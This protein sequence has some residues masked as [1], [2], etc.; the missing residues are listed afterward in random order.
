MEDGE[1][2][3]RADFDAFLDDIETFLNITKI[4]DDNIQNSGITGSTKLLNQSVTAAKLAT[5]SVETAKIADDAVTEAKIGDGAVTSDKLGAS[6]VVEAKIADDAVTS[7]KIADDA[8]TTDAIADDA[9]TD[10]KLSADVSVDAN[11]AV[12]T[13]HIRDSAVT[14]AKINDGAVTSAK[15]GV[16]YDT[17]TFSKVVTRSSA[18]TAEEYVTFSDLEC[19]GRPVMLIVWSGSVAMTGSTGQS[20]FGGV[21]WERVDEDDESTEVATVYS[22]AVGESTKFGMNNGGGG[23]I[24]DKDGYAILI[25]PDPGT[26]TMTYRFKV[27]AT[28]TNGGTSTTTLTSLKAVIFEL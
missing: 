3:V 8:V 14:E 12:T 10:A 22:N 24:F 15:K 1:V 7:G 17:Q 19:S 6:A 16:F 18:G 13:D 11:R 21:V 2:L 25:D 9:V 23:L 20:N 27:S 26:G 28:V 4:N 5:G